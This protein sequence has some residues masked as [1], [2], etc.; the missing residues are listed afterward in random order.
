MLEVA[1]PTATLQ[2][3]PGVTAIAV[4]RAFAAAVALLAE[5]M[6][7]F[8]VTAHMC[9]RTSSCCAASFSATLSVWCSLPG[10]CSGV[11]QCAALHQRLGNVSRG[12]ARSVHLP[13]SEGRVARM[14]GCN[15]QHSYNSS[16]QCE[17]GNLQ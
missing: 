1:A 3:Q 14:F 2:Q 11:L 9:A 6:C 10:Q 4:L 8:L 13:R 15:M 17:F 16:A 5:L 12:G 7:V